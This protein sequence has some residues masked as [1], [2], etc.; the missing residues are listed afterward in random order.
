MK[1]D[2]KDYN[3]VKEVDNSINLYNIK[4][5]YILL[6]IWFLN[7][8]YKNEID[9]IAINGQTGKFVGD[10]PIDR[11]KVIFTWIILFII[12]FAILLLLNIIKVSL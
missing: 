2:I 4:S 10:I 6:P 8:K 12:I 11:K 1:K 5:N 7:I 3:K 9:T